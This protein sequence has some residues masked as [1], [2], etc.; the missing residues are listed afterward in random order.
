MNARL[1]WRIN[2]PESA[3]YPR[4]K[5]FSAP[6][7]FLSH[8]EHWPSEAWSL[9]VQAATPVESDGTQLVRVRF[10]VDEAPHH[11]LT[12][13]SKFELYEGLLML[14]DGVVES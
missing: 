4:G 11:W 10:F 6:A 14:A 12:R 7:R 1:T 13:G 3:P 5:S 8:Y 2:V 9:V